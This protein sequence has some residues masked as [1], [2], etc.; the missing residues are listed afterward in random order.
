VTVR[1][2]GYIQPN[3]P[4]SFQVAKISAVSR[5]LEYTAIPSMWTSFQED[6]EAAKEPWE[7]RQ[8]TLST[9]GAVKQ[10]L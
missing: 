3:Q 7:S 8:S 10:K 1:D 5:K 2:I 4:V 9:Q 6:K